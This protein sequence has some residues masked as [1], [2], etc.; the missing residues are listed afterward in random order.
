MIYYLLLVAQVILIGTKKDLVDDDKTL[1]SLRDLHGPEAQPISRSEGDAL[2]AE[3]K[4]EGYYE[5]SSKTNEGV[6]EAFHA[7]ISAAESG[8]ERKQRWCQCL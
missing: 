7:A 5:T 3:I 6:T 1:K 8:P 4:A 2:A